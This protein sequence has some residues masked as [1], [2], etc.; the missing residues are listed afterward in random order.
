MA[1]QV[2]PLTRTGIYIHGVSQTVFP[3][4]TAEFQISE[5][6]LGVDIAVIMTQFK[7]KGWTLVWP[8]SEMRFGV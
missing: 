7:D 1:S 8:L 4:H 5:V 3:R 6:E 2:L